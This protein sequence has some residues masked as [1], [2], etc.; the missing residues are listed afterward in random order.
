M[1]AVAFGPPLIPIVQLIVDVQLEAAYKTLP[2][3]TFTDMNVDVLIL[4]FPDPAA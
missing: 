4:P 2:L 3:L 1:L